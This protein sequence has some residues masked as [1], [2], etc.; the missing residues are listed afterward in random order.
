MFINRILY[1]SEAWHGVTEGHILKLSI[2]DHN[3]MLFI[4][5]THASNPTEF[6]YLEAGVISV[7]F[8]MSSCRMNYRLEIHNIEEHELLKQ[9]YKA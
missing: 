4:L 1:N 9:V 2:V 6:L 8:V 7:R 3:L 5:S